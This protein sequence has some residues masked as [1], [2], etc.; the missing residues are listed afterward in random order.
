VGASGTL[1]GWRCLEPVKR[2]MATPRWMRGPVAVGKPSDPGIRPCLR[3][4]Q[5]T[6]ATADPV[7]WNVSA[8]ATSARIPL[9]G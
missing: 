8:S 2:K 7:I 1:M 6:Y 3:V 9:M 4:S 5:G